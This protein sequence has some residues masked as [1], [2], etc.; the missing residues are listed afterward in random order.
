MKSFP[1]GDWCF[2]RI[3][4]RDKNEIDDM[5]LLEHPAEI[6]SLFGPG[7][8]EGGDMGECDVEPACW[9]LLPIVFAK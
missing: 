3:S 5:S 7:K 1:S 6:K 8:F 4:I 2:I 9:T